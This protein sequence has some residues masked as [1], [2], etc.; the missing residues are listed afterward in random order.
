MGELK[1]LMQVQIIKSELASMINNA[2]MTQALF[3]RKTPAVISLMAR[4]LL[5]SGFIFF[6]E[7]RTYDT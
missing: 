1:S 5:L 6:K 7:R 2:Y 3:C 4:V